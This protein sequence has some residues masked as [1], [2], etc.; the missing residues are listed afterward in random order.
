MAHGALKSIF[1]Q[2]EESDVEICDEVYEAYTE[3]LRQQEEDDDTLCYKTYTL[4]SCLITYWGALKFTLGSSQLHIGEF[5]ST[6]W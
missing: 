6:H 5:S 3:L 4:V 2:L 1:L